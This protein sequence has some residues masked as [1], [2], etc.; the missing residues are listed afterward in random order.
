[1]CIRDRRPHI[2]QVK[3]ALDAGQSLGEFRAKES[4]SV[5]DDADFHL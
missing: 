3:D 4:V 5:T 2:A 1:M